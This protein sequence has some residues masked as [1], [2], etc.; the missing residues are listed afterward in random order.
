LH[1][2][3]LDRVVVLHLGHDLRP[4]PG[5]TLDNLIASI[6]GDR[7]SSQAVMLFGNGVENGVETGFWK[8]NIKK[9]RNAKVAG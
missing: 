6:I 8:L 3:E 2:N 4:L 7:P 9:K 1:S 5:H